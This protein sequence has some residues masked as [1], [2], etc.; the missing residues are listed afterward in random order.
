[1]DGE[2]WVRS[3]SGAGYRVEPSF[4]IRDWRFV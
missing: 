3:V 2:D 1:A 4:G